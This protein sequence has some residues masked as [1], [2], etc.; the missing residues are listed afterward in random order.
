[1]KK[2]RNFLNYLSKIIMEN[3]IYSFIQLLKEFNK[4]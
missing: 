1:M 3:D 4:P 2:I